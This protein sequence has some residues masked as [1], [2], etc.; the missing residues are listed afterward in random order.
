MPWPQPTDYNEAVQEPRLCFA[1]PELAS[2][3]VTVGP[4]GLPQAHSGNFADV[5][6]VTS[7]DGK[8]RWAVKCFT[9]QVE[10]LQRRYQA[11]SEHLAR[12]QLR[13]TVEFHYLSEGIR[14]RGD[15]FPV[16]KMRWVEGLA[17]NEF[18]RRHADRPVYLLRLAE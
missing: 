15:W 5:Y 4:L 14:V 16:L 11:V 12:A 18:V 2:G 7:A 10:N 6:Q 13:F 9:R 1:D 3:Q 17:L 8:Q